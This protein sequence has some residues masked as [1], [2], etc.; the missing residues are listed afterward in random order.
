MREQVFVR[1][2]ALMLSGL[3]VWG[4]H[5]TLVY[6]FNAFICARGLVGERFLGMAVVPFGIGAITLIALLLLAVLLLAVTIGGRPRLAEVEGQAV[7]GFTRI[8]TLSVL[9][10]ATLAVLA[11]AAPA[12]IVPACA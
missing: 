7:R 5:F 11:Q 4:G 1:P 3:L 10:Y 12:Y 2:F 9:A 8:L 6:A